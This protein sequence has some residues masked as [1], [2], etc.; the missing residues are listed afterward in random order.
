MDIK[1]V[2]RWICWIR[3]DKGTKM[4]C[5]RWGQVDSALNELI[6]CSFE[7]VQEAYEL[8]KS[9]LAGVGFV[10]TPDLPFIG[11]DLDDATH[12]WNIDEWALP[13]HERLRKTYHELSPSL[14]GVKYWGLGKKPE[15]G[16][17]QARVGPGQIE[18]YDSGRWFAWTGLHLGDEPLPVV[19]IQSDVD[20]LYEHYLHSRDVER[21]IRT[22]QG[23]SI[24][25]F[26]GGN[27]ES[28]LR[29]Y[30]DAC[31]R[32]P[33]VKGERNNRLFSIAKGLLDF[34]D[35]T[36]EMVSALMAEFN[37]RISEPLPADELEA[38]CKSASR[39]NGR[40]QQPK[41]DRP[42]ELAMPEGVDLSELMANLESQRSQAIAM[43]TKKPNRT[44]PPFPESCLL[45]PGF[46]G[47]FV[48]EQLESA[49]YPQPQLAWGAAMSTLSVVTGRKVQD[50][51][52]T[53]TNLY[54]ISVAKTG[55]GKD[56][57]RTC[58]L[59]L[60]EAAEAGHLIGFE[61]IASSSGLVSKLAADPASVWHLD[62]MG[63]MLE[64]IKRDSRA[65][66]LH[67]IIS[68]MLQ[69][70]TSSARTWRGDAYADPSRNPV[71][72]Q[73][74][75]VVYGSTTPDAFWAALDSRSMQDGFIGRLSP[76]FGEYVGRNKSARRFQ[77]SEAMVDWVR[78]WS[79]SA[80]GNLA[81]LN[82]AMIQLERSDDAHDR[83]CQHVD[84]IA[85][86]RMHESDDA[87]AIWSRVG[88]RSAKFAMLFAIS[89]G[90]VS[91][92]KYTGVC[93][94]DMNRGIEASI[95]MARAMLENFRDNVADNQFEAAAIRARKIVLD[96]C[97]NEGI[98]RWKLNRRLRC[99]SPRLR[100]EV[101]SN[102]MEAGELELIPLESGG[103]GYHAVPW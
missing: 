56:H 75:L 47:Q 88:E 39:G 25:V 95:W 42:L 27:L 98:P 21:I 103:F 10:F 61:R 1:E 50:Y 91:G 17:S 16:R 51:L 26:G 12:Q 35:V 3:N 63:R 7:Q 5:N 94:D 62:E 66:H 67:S 86:R 73:P 34:P 71:I 41:E 101:I 92:A 30:L 13:I 70:Y 36:P 85:E 90:M 9:T 87:A 8:R 14:S 78:L 19:D 2:D 38:I 52:G 60:L 100:E 59:E 11:V 55:S 20:W 83:W 6:W 64:S 96:L 44:M 74:H 43:A 48:R 49:L 72:D 102:M 69:L 4:P 40:P 53:R 24:Q 58:A 65:T 57:Y 99:V 89:R 93:L 18:C 76:V 15:G 45:A 29:G 81:E 54:L 84:A 22:N 82:P 31:L 28:R 79:G 32:T 46:I 33:P 37:Q 77:P 80:D 97:K 23:Q 68:V